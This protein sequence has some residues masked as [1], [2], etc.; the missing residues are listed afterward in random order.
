MLGCG[1]EA[2]PSWATECK[3]YYLCYSK[4]A[5]DAGVLEPTYG[6]HGN[7][8]KTTTAVATACAEKCDEEFHALLVAFPDAGC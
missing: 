5:G 7:C 2:S 3:N 6:L 8:W 1:E 4:A